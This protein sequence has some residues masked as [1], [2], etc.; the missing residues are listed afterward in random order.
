MLLTLMA[1]NA[2]SANITTQEA[3]QTNDVSSYQTTDNT[4]EDIAAVTTQYNLFITI[5]HYFWNV[6]DFYTFAMTGSRDP[7]MYTRDPHKIASMPT[8][9]PESLIRAEDI[10]D[11]T[12]SIVHIGDDGTKYEYRYFIGGDSD[13]PFSHNQAFSIQVFY[14]PEIFT[15]ASG[16]RFGMRSKKHIEETENNEFSMDAEFKCAYVKEIDGLTVYR[17]REDNDSL[18]F[19]VTIDGFLIGIDYWY[20]E[21]GLNDPNNQC[22][23]DFFDNER[24]PLVVDKLKSSVEKAKSTQW[25]LPTP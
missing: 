12:P 25:Y 22:F 1:C 17:M 5:A 13:K 16:D 4:T 14:K 7:S 10:I 11:R 8:V 18:V 9:K 20:K 2:N 24:L 23:M 6:D 3:N 21:E 19:G 15:N